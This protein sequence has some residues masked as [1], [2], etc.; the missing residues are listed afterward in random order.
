MIMCIFLSYAFSW[1][2]WYCLYYEIYGVAQYHVPQLPCD[3]GL[4]F[5]YYIYH[6]DH[7]YFNPPLKHRNVVHFVM[8]WVWHIYS[9]CV[10]FPACDVMFA[11]TT[12]C[13]VPCV[14]GVVLLS[15]SV[16]YIP[17]TKS[18]RYT[19]L[20][21]SVWSIILFASSLRHFPSIFYSMHVLL[22]AL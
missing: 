17:V 19:H 3:L 21:W 16:L 9:L 1:S 2:C 6:H 7:V 4:F 15:R 20:S 22:S 10:T 18:T 5:Q 8:I 11:C 14:S 13:L 12:I